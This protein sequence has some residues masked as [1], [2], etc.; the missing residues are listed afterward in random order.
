MKPRESAPR[1]PPGEQAKGV[2]SR[3]IRLAL[4]PEMSDEGHAML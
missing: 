3:T 1:I 2:G 4:S